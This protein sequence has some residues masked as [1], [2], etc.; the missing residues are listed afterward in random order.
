[1]PFPADITP[2]N[3]TDLR[4]GDALAVAELPVIMEIKQ[5]R[6]G[7][8]DLMQGRTA[9]DLVRH[10]E[11][12]GAP[13]VSVVTGSWFGGT[14]RLLDEVVEATS[15]PVLV[16]DF[17]TK[18]KQITQ[19]A[20]AGAA[21][22][23]LTATI[24]PHRL[25]A[26]LIDACL[27]RGV[28][29]FVEITSGAEL[30]ALTRPE[31]CV[32]AVNNTDIRTRESDEPDLGRSHDLLPRVRAAS[33]G[34]AVSA[35]GIATPE[36]AAGLLAAGFR[37]LLIGTGLLRAED[38]DAWFGDLRALLPGAEQAAADGQR[39][40]AAEPSARTAAAART[41]RAAAAGSAPSTGAAAA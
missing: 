30:S 37:G 40:H 15:L 29:P 4:F 31:A 17:F 38:L 24:L 13:A 22:V 8:E 20:E 28:T 5:S 21:A 9:G 39:R 7:G 1:M 35:S 25:M 11:E 18:E 34:L 36:E 16:K 33:A 12:L 32:V 3:A 41:G 2:V 19:A 6:A 14:A 27:A 10:Y 23:L 26:V